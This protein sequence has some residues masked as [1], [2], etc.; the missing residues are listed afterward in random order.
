V[1][2]EGGKGSMT[3]RLRVSS[4]RELEKTYPKGKCCYGTICD[5]PEGKVSESRSPAHDK[6]RL[7]RLDRLLSDLVTMIMVN[8]LL[9]PHL[10][11]HYS[12][13]SPFTRVE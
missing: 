12:L 11:E 3:A 6:P 4:L 9:V 5:L 7:L 10:S 8:F 13:P 2:E 1:L